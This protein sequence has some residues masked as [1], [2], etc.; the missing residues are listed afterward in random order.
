MKRLVFLALLSM[1]GLGAGS[2]G[3]SQTP[4]DVEAVEAAVREYYHAIKIYDYDAMRAAATPEF[5]IVYGGRRVNRSEFE[6]VHRAEEQELG[7][8]ESRPLR[9]GY[10]LA[11]FEIEI[12][13]DVAF[14]R[15]IEIVPN[16]EYPD[17]HGFIVL[18]RDGG[19]WAV[20]RMFTMPMAEA[21]AE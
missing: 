15:Y 9:L 17:Y 19:R 14:C 10:E 2:G 8:V 4:S 7:P 12:A 5:E 1:V 13:G 11:E 3:L 16:P 6:T 21:T 18:L 20:H